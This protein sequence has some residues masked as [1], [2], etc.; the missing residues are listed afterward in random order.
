MAMLVI[1][2]WYH[3]MSQVSILLSAESVPYQEVKAHFHQ[4]CWLQARNYHGFGTFTIDFLLTRGYANISIYNIQ[5][6]II[7]I[8]ILLLL[9][10]LIIVLIIIIL[11]IYCLFIYIYAIMEPAI[12]G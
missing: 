9:I 6:I 8:T 4:H 7:N 10:I 11:I 1:T 2:L 3:V 12:D 5:H